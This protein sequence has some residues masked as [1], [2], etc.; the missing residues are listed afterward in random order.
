MCP[1]FIVVV[2][3]P[4][5]ITAEKPLCIGNCCNDATEAVSASTAEEI[6]LFMSYR[7]VPSH[8]IT[9]ATLVLRPG[10]LSFH[11]RFH[12]RMEEVKTL[13]AD[14]LPRRETGR[15]IEP[16]TGGRRVLEQVPMPMASS[17]GLSIPLF[18]LCSCSATSLP[19]SLQPKTRHRQHTSS[20][21]RRALLTHHITNPH[22]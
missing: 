21:A 4:T 8:N 15:I 7:S 20:C 11:A 16:R 12:S 13:P 3:I 14:I 17:Q 19:Q 2:S 10:H 1:I 9:R 6:L 22:A 5:A 18:S